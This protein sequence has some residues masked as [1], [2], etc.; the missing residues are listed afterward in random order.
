L[1]LVVILHLIETPDE[2]MLLKDFKETYGTIV[3]GIALNSNYWNKAFYPLFL[4]RRLVYALILITLINYPLLQLIVILGVV[5]IPV[6][7]DN[8]NNIDVVLS[9]DHK[10]FRHHIDKLFEHIQRAGASADIRVSYLPQY[11]R[12]GQRHYELYGSELDRPHAFVLG[13]HLVH[14][15]PTRGLRD[16]CQSWGMV[17]EAMSIFNAH[18]FSAS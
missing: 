3:E 16:G 10:T 1:T 5:L 18:N 8:N 7:H 11:H 13:D 12:C 2:E 9:G 6:R 14:P 4:T 17:S 15:A